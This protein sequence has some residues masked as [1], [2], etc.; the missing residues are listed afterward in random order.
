MATTTKK[1]KPYHG[2]PKQE[3]ASASSNQRGQSGLE[4]LIAAMVVVDTGGSGD[5][6]NRFGNDGSNC[7]GSRS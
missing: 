7:G 1:Q 2:L 6:Y 3:M 4:T 5:G